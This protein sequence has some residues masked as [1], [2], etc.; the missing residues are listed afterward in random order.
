MGIRRIRETNK[1]QALL[2]NWLW[3]CGFEEGSQWQRVIAAKYDVFNNWETYRVWLPM[4]LVVGKAYYGSNERVKKKN[5]ILVEIG[6]GGSDNFF[7]FHHCFNSNKNYCISFMYIF[8][9]I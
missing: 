1:A 6:L 7:K 9:F 8:T 5:T 2:S 4:V 3:R